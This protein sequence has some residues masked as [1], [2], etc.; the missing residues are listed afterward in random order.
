MTPTG[1]T[2]LQGEDADALLARVRRPAWVAT[3]DLDARAA[4]A[5]EIERLRAERD[6]LAAAVEA[7]RQAGRAEGLAAGRLAAR[8]EVDALRALVDSALAAVRDAA[9]EVALAA[10]EELVHAESLAAPESFCARVAD[11]LSASAGAVVRIRVA[12]ALVDAAR[13][14]VLGAIASVAAD[15]TLLPGD[16]VVEL[17]SG[18]LDLRV[19]TTLEAMLPGIRAAL[20]ATDGSAP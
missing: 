1:W 20:G 11:A 13:Q 8:A 7:A 18:Q 9:S 4:L 19:T 12:P 10:A 16:A 5:A 15:A 14:S 3:A 6:D 17:R 2:R